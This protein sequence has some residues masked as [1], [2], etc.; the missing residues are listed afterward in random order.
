MYYQ[1][2]MTNDILIIDDNSD[3]RELISGI[4]KDQG[5][6]VREAANFD[7][8]LLEIKKKYQT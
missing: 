7:Q 1:N 3:I 6:I 5:F 4:L 8:A 2:I